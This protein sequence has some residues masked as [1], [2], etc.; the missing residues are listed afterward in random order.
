MNV[1]CI[2]FLHQ[3]H[4][5]YSP[6]CPAGYQLTGGGIKTQFPSFTRKNG[7]LES[8]PSSGRWRCD[9]DVGRGFVTCFARCCKVSSGKQ[10]HRLSAAPTASPTAVMLPK[11]RSDITFV[12]QHHEHSWNQ[13]GWASCMER[14][15]IHSLEGARF[16]SYYVRSL[17]PLH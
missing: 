2:L 6:R 16:P 8:M 4:A 5:H 11:C 10:G 14:S 17:S 7:H 3:K 13:L 9:A 1:C 12:R 15:G